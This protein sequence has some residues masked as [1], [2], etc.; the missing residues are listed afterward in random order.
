M[1]IFGILSG[2][3]DEN[4]NGKVIYSDQNAERKL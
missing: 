2:I 3:S 1:Q 4:I